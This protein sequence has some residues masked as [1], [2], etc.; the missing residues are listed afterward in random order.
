[1]GTHRS[2]SCIRHTAVYLN[3]HIRHGRCNHTRRAIGFL[4]SVYL[5]K[6]AKP[7]LRAVAESAVSL[8][9]GIPSVV[10]GLVGMLVLVPGIR[11]AFNLA[12]GFRP[13]GRNNRTCD[14]DSALDHKSVY[15]CS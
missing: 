11:N 6:A 4:A 14:Y 12:D 8:L 3:E 5:A 10:Y 9:A 13:L 2:D 7:K 1:M 15:D